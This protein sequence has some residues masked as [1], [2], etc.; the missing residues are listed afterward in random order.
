MKHP[1]EVDVEKIMKALSNERRRKVILFLR[2]GEKTKREIKSE[3]KCSI[4]ATRRHLQLLKEIGIIRV[5]RREG[6][7]GILRNYYV[8]VPGRLE[9]TAENLAIWTLLA[10]PEV[11]IPGRVIRKRVT[12]DKEGLSYCVA[13]LPEYSAREKLKYLIKRLGLAVEREVPCVIVESP[14]D[15][16]R[17]Y[18]INKDCVTIGS[19]ENNDIVIRMDP[20]VSPHHA[21]IL[22]ERYT[23]MDL[24]LIEDLNSKRGTL[25]VHESARANWDSLFLY[26]GKGKVPHQEELLLSGDA[27]M[28]GRTW[29]RFIESK[30]T[31]KRNQS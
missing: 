27:F 5:F 22:R 30:E 25:V 28:V 8:L 12:W 16:G 10:K 11:S 31:K 3:I 13:K 24:Y 29:L 2:S 21:R 9:A 15:Y 14:I 18:S 26:Y 23:N 7:D 6:D 17:E 1:V 20:Y 19:N 4:E